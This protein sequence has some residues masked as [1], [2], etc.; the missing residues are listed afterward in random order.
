MHSADEL[1]QCPDYRRPDDFTWMRLT[2]P[3]KSLR[4]RGRD[5]N[6]IGH[7]NSIVSGECV[8]ENNWLFHQCVR[9]V[10]RLWVL[11]KHAAV[12]AVSLADISRNQWI[13]PKIYI[14]IDT[15]NCADSKFRLNFDL[16]FI[17]M[18][19]PLQ[20]RN[21]LHTIHFI[22][23]CRYFILYCRYFLV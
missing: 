1:S 4:P 5:E 3:L 9:G 15:V 22:L 21:Y 6:M 2:N 14:S 8:E 20:R 10:T 7:I 16:N 23:Y 17:Y 12:L 18:H 11:E 13:Y 19:L